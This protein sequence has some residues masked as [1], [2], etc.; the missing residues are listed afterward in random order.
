MALVPERKILS[1]AQAT[2]SRHDAHLQKQRQNRIR[3][4][5]FETFG[6]H[7]V[8]M[9]RTTVIEWINV[10]SDPLWIDVQKLPDSLAIRS[11]NLYIA[12]NFQR[13]ST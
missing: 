9:K 3:Q 4:R 11:R 8:S 7:Y 10:L 12:L 5:L 1:L 13:V 2:F 6:L